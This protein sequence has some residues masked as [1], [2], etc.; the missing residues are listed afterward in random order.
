VTLQA[1]DHPSHFILLVDA[2]GSTATPRAAASFRAALARATEGLF[3]HGF[4]EP[5]PLFRPDQDLLTLL[6]FGIVEGSD[7]STAYRR[8]ANYDVLTQL[9]HPVWVRRSNVSQEELER[10]IH[11]STHYRL[12]LMNWVTQL[13]LYSARA[14]SGRSPAERTFLIKVQDG[15]PNQGTLGG[16]IDLV[17]AWGRKGA[18]DEVE[19]RVL[20]IASGYSL[21]NVLTLPV[22]AADGG[23]PIFL[24]VDEV[25]STDQEAW[26][27]ALRKVDPFTPVRWLWSDESSSGGE[28]QLQLEVGEELS[29]LLQEAGATI[30]VR[31]PSLQG[32][33]FWKQDHG[34]SVTVAVKS[35]T[36]LTCAATP[37]EIVLDA[38]PRRT[39][40]ILGTTVYDY[41]VT[42]PFMAPP[43]GRCEA[44]RVAGRWA[45]YLL[46]AG[47][48]FLAIFVLVFRRFKTLVRVKLPGKGK[49]VKLRWD[50]PVLHRAAL[51]VN[52]GSQFV[53]FH[54]PAYLVQ[55][56]VYRH[57]VLTVRGAA[58]EELEWNHP[59]G[60]GTVRLPIAARTV[61]LLWKEKAREADWAEVIFDIGS[62]RTSVQLGHVPARDQEEL[63][64]E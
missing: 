51:T 44:P 34:R 27:G 38:S 11:P 57:A 17:K 53:R 9:V 3:E 36:A 15:N 24:S 18:Y 2:S 1:H 28:G 33:A 45:L 8:L 41:Q 22:R 58:A 54:L 14:D 64:N 4:G 26:R 50:G 39:D 16:E 37:V 31:A 30:D 47:T 7:A 62:R 32:H 59:D 56:L 21:K 52:P 43:P 35:T 60:G 19:R 63:R 25:L 29:R 23:E 12:T 42:I 20:Q 40:G 49:L 13:A 6:D 10:A 5:V 48:A 46:I 61:S 55:A